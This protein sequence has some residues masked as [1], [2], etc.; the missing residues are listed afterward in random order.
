MWL[1]RLLA[2]L[3]VLLWNNKFSLERK[4]TS[5]LLRV[6]QQMITACV[7]K[8]KYIFSV[9][10]E[11]SPEAKS[12]NSRAGRTVLSLLRFWVEICSLFLLA[13][14]DDEQALVVFDR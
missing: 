9:S 10:L 4:K 3:A 2:K 7:T 6:L 13:S 14:S 11:V 8:Q 5:Y 12:L 1:F